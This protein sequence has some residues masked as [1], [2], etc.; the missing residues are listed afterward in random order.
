MKPIVG[1]A[2]GAVVGLLLSLAAEQAMA[3]TAVAVAKER[4]EMMGSL[5]PSYYKDLNAVAAGQDTNIAA[6]S[7][8]AQAASAAVKKLAGLFPPGTGRDAAPE[9]RSTPEVWSQRAEFEA[10]FA[11]LVSET[12]KLGEAAKSGSLDAFKAQ[13]A[14]VGKAC[15]G[16]HGGLIKSGGK[17]RFEAQ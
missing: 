10:A 17:F 3:Q 16:C 2:G 6:S 1:L 9:T 11:A 13:W 12:D 14:A 7:T 4:K 15:G 5:W 8:K